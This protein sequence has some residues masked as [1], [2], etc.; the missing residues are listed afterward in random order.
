MNQST[1]HINSEYNLEKMNQKLHYV[2]SSISSELLKLQA[3]SEKLTTLLKTQFVSLEEQELVEEQLDKFMYEYKKCK[4]L[5]NH[6]REIRI[7]KEMKEMELHNQK[8]FAR[9][10][11]VQYGIDNVVDIMQNT[12]KNE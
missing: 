6:G 2:E 5:L 1:L 11:L 10:V 4:E 3:H 7:H 8:R 12:S 9:N